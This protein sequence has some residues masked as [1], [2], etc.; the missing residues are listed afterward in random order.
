MQYRYQ[1]AS[2]SP[3]RRL[4]VSTAATSRSLTSL[5]RAKQSL[6]ITDTSQDALLTELIARASDEVVAYLRLSSTDDGSISTLARQTY[7]ETMRSQGATYRIYLMR[8]PI[9]SITSIVV[10]DVELTQDTDYLLASAQGAIDRLSGDGIT[11]WAFE[12]AVV[13]YV[14]GH[15][16][17]GEEGRD[18]PYDIEEAVHYTISARMADLNAAAGDREVRSE[19]LQGV[20]SATY[21]TTGANRFASGQYLP[22]RAQALLAKY[23][24]PMI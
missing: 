13:T 16:L 1:Q 3:H 5:A 24:T 18:L 23:R 8:R 2:P 12:K 11:S 10:D 20:Y 9:A 19:T 4:I 14:A 6:G 15:L 17:P 7:V 22:E 21:E